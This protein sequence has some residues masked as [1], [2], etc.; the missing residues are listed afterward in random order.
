MNKSD[1]FSNSTGFRSRDRDL[2]L[3]KKEYVPD[4]SSMTKTLMDF[5]TKLRKHYRDFVPKKDFTNDYTSKN[6]V[7]T[8]EDLS[9]SSLGSNFGNYQSRDRLNSSKYQKYQTSN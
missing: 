5:R 1:L 7:R 2:F 9:F 6:K 3:A 4:S 8:N